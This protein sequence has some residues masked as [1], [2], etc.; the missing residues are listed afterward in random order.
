MPFL[1]DQ[2]LRGA[3]AAR[4]RDKALQTACD[5]TNDTGADSEDVVIGVSIT[6]VRPAEGIS[7]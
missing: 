2:W 5:N 4:T 6:P 7:G 3:L 1:T